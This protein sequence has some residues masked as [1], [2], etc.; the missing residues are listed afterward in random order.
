MTILYRI[1][2]LAFFLP[3]LVAVSCLCWLT[4][5]IGE[6]APVAHWFMCLWA[7]LSLAVSGVEVR[8]DL[9]ALKPG[10]PCVFLANHQSQFDILVLVHALRGWNVRFVAKESLFKIPVF[11]PAMRRT[12]HI[13][14]LREN[15]RKAM[16]SIDDAVAAAKKGISV[17]VFPEGTRSHDFSRL[18]EFKI[19]GMIMAL[20]C[21]IPVAPVIVSGSGEVLPRGKWVPKPGVVHV[22]ALPAFDPAERFTIREREAFRAWLQDYMGA[23]YQEVRQCPPQ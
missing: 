9:S 10:Q 14:I 13:P 4:A 12:G 20:K 19:G 21:G 2:Y 18:G 5:G 15:S 16:K 22:K 3:L 6:N 1:T 8:A 11:G 7:R 23:A 17:V